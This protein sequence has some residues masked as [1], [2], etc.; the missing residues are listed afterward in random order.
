M[1]IG[2]VVRI[3][4]CSLI[5]GFGAYLIFSTVFPQYSVSVLL[6]L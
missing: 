4:F 6:G 2:K 3:V 1:G 5:I